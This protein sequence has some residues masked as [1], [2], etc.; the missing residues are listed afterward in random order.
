MDS[1]K[2]AIH[3]HNEE[4]SYSPKWV[5]YCDKHGIEYKIVNCYDDDII[6]QLK[7]CDGLMWHWIH[8]DYRAQL[9]A[10]QLIASLDLI[11]FPVYPD[12]KTSWHFDDKVG[13]KYLLEAIDAPM[14]RSYAF[15][16]KEK[17]L[18]WI[19]ETTF[20]K[21][22]KLRGGAGAYNV[23]LIYTK[24]EAV[25]Y[26][27][28]AFGKGFEAVDRSAILKERIWHFKRDKSL[29]KFID[30]GRGVA[31]IL[32]PHKQASMLPIEKNYLYAQDF[33]DG[34]DHDIR[35]FVIGDRAT[36]K[37]RFVREDD[38]RASG[39]GKMSWDIGEEGKECVRKAFDVT[40]KLQAQSLAFDFVL[41]GDEYKIVEISYTASVR[42]FPDAPGYWSSE[43]EWLEKPFRVEYFMVEDF[44]N[45]L[46]KKR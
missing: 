9:F 20:P 1:V 16:E 18:K 29:K 12:L 26:V 45:L 30:I 14:V 41:D 28:K 17:S 37:K 25:K 32:L 35:V 5:E 4:D 36:T 38:F 34:C 39:S 10:R 3:H 7:D 46:Q 15:Y 21:V 19:N 22:F 31:R 33:I 6:E 8:L 40:K 43:V 2:L 23:K 13:Q 27:N 42:G 24:E 11:D 44:V